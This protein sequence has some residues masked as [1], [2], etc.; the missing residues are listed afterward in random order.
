VRNPWIPGNGFFVNGPG[1]AGG[2]AQI[3]LT[4]QGSGPIQDQILV[5]V[6]DLDPLAGPNG[7]GILDQFTVSASIDW[8]AKSAAA[9]QAAQNARPELQAWLDA[10]MTDQVAAVDINCDGQLNAADDWG[11]FGGPGQET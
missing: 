4:P 5:T 6:C 1:C 9:V 2:D 3:S 8:Q 11:A 7:D 10:N